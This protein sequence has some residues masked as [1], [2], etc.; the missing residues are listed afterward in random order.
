MRSTGF[1][2]QQRNQRYCFFSSGGELPREVPEEQR[3]ASR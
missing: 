3:P 2:A 1:S